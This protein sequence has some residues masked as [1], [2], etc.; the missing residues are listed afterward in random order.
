MDNKPGG[1]KKH[2]LVIADCYYGRMHAGR[3]AVKNLFDRDSTLILL[4][5]YQPPQQKKEN[6][7]GISPLLRKI[8]E[9][10]L[11]EFKARLLYEF[12]IPSDK[13]QT[14][15]SEGELSQIINDDF[16]DVP[17]LSIVIG[18]MNE[19]SSAKIP[20]W[21]V[22]CSL[23]EARVRP[24]FLITDC[25]SVIESSRILVIAGDKDP[26]TGNYLCFVEDLKDKYN[27]ELEILTPDDQ[28]KIPMNEESAVHFKMYSELEKDHSRSSEKIFY[29]RVISVSP[30]KG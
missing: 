15:V 23:M 18:S 24:V 11:R 1:S 29:D 14:L 4:Q 3:F 8:A 25:I 5:T 26:K 16:S 22:I 2:I 20:C 19:G 30:L 13:V 12:D 9:R 6:G 28:K 17:N 21:N 7:E 27:C 10:E